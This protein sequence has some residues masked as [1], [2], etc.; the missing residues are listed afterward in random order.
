MLPDPK[1]ITHEQIYI[2]SSMLKII[3]FQMNKIYIIE[4][5]LLFYDF[6]F[7]PIKIFFIKL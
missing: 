3:Q 6:N 7:L 5:F 2:D 4:K 1:P